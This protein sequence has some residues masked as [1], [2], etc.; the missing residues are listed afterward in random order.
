LANYDYVGS[1]PPLADYGVTSMKA[2]TRAAVEK[3]HAEQM[4]ANTVFDFRRD[5][6]I[7]CT[8]DVNVLM[9]AVCRFRD[10][11]LA[12]FHVDPFQVATTIASLC[13]HV[14]RANFLPANAIGIVPFMGYRKND[15]QR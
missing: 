15:I 6:G 13:M 7:Y 5:I 8:Q 11:I 2:S 10:M 1:L 12:Q 9:Q 3:W 14:Y 4:A